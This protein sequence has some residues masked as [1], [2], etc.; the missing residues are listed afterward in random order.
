MEDKLYEKLDIRKISGVPDS[1]DPN[2]DDFFER[3]ENPTY[4]VINNIKQMSPRVKV[5]ANQ[6]QKKLK[7]IRD[8]VKSKETVTSVDRSRVYES[9]LPIEI[10]YNKKIERIRT[11]EY[12]KNK[13]PKP[14]HFDIAESY[15]GIDT[16]KL[17]RI[18]CE[19]APKIYSFELNLADANRQK[20]FETVMEEIARKK[21]LE[22]EEPLKLT[23]FVKGATD[24][25]FIMKFMKELRNR[26]H[27]H[28]INL[29]S[30]H[31]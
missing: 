4:G 11:N 5:D 10:L 31:K 21:R 26:M 29:K 3:E 7:I 28:E 17:I 23:D 15:S 6:L 19:S 8:I 14:I 27:V 20:H 12:S 22:Q 16:T 18:E 13:P 9:K 25:S 24:N 30:L 1:Y 2:L